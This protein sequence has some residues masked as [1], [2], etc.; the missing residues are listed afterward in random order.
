MLSCLGLDNLGVARP[1]FKLLC[2]PI[3]RRFAD[4]VLIYDELVGL[5]GLQAGHMW[6]LE[7]FVQD[8]DVR[9]LEQVP[10]SGPLLIVS[11]HPGVA[12]GSALM[13]HIERPDLRIVAADNAFIRALPQTSRYLFFMDNTKATRLHLVRRATRHLRDGGALLLFPAGEIE[14]DPAILPGAVDTLDD[15]TLSMDLFARLV[16]EIVIVPAVVSHVLSPR[17]LQTRLVRLRQGAD[18]R[19]RLAALLQVLLPR[20]HD[21]V[22]QLT[23]GT[24]VRPSAVA[25]RSD[26]RASQAVLAEMRR[27]LQANGYSNGD[28]SIS[29]AFDI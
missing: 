14:P 28:R 24:P 10:A 8:V 29:N 26:R 5:A 1:W 7:Q 11:N 15:W 6:M 17:V 23:F 2:R 3:A 13:A 18:E 19:R 21:N 4:Q 12:D 20:L 27:L 16:P 25:H 9:G 22:V